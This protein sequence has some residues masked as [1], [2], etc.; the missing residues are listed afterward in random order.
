M[1]HRIIGWWHAR[2]RVV[3]LQ[4]LWSA[5]VENAS[6]LDQ[7]KAAFAVHAFNDAAWL[8]LGE[9]EIARQIDELKGTPNAD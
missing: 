4:I 3:D 9:D 7:A 5:C 6:N 1:L 2:Q 8:W